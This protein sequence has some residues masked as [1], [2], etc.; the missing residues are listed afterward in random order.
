M[1]TY[2]NTA[3]VIAEDAFENVVRKTVDILSWL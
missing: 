3:I 1:R 2:K